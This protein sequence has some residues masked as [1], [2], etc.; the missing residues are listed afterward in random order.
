MQQF[1]DALASFDAS[2]LLA[3]DDVARPPAIVGPSIVVTFHELHGLVTAVADALADAALPVVAI[4]LP[5]GVPQIAVLYGATVTPSTLFLPIDEMQSVARNR[6]L[7]RD[8]ATT[9]LVCSPTSRLLEALQTE[10]G[11]AIAVRPL[12]L[13]LGDAIVL[14]TWRSAEMAPPIWASDAD[15]MY[16]LYTSGSTGHPKGVIGSY[17]ATWHRLAWMWSTVPFA[18]GERVLRHTALTSSATNLLGPCLRYVVVSGEPLHADLIAA[19]FAALPY[20]QLLHLY[21]STEVAGDATFWLTTTTAA[22]VPIGTAIGATKLRLVDAE[23]AEIASDETRGELYIGGPPLARGYVNPSDNESHRFCMLHGERW[24]K[25]GDVAYWSKGL[26]FFCGRT[27]AGYV[28]VSGVQVHVAAIETTVRTYLGQHY[29]KWKVALA[30]IASSEGWHQYDTLV[31]C[32]GMDEDDTMDIDA[33]RDAVE[34]E[35]PRVAMHVLTVPIARFPETSSG[36]ADPSQIPAL[37]AQRSLPSWLRALLPR[38]SGLASTRLDPSTTLTELGLNSM[39]MAIVLHTLQSQHEM[40]LR[41]IELADMTVADLQA[42]VQ[43]KRPRAISPEASRKRTRVAPRMEAV[44]WRVRAHKCID[45]SPRL[46]T[47]DV[48]EYIIVGSHDHTVLCVAAVDGHVVW[49]KELPDRVESSAAVAK[50]QVVVGCYDGGVYCLDVLSGSTLWVFF[51]QDQVKCS[52]VIVE[53]E[54]AVVVGSHD[55]HV[56]G[57]A[58][59]S[60]ACLFKLPFT[61]SVFSSPVYAATVL[62]CA[63]LAGE[64]R[65]YAW[66]SLRHDAPT[67]L[68]QHT[69]PAPVFCSLRLSARQSVLLV[70]CADASLYAL[71]TTTGTPRWSA[72][73]TKPIFSAPRIATLSSGNEVALFGSHDGVVRC[74]STADGVTL[75]LVDLGCTIYASP[76]I[77]SDR[78]TTLRTCVCTT[79]GHVYLWEPEAPSSPATLLF[80]GA[81]DIFS[82]PLVLMDESTIVVGTRGDVLVALHVPE[83][84]ASSSTMTQ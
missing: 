61:K 44:R 22:P 81:G 68:W 57:L 84:D 52:P 50:N 53:E 38:T 45:A 36:K 79:D 34:R 46:A 58:L 42:L 24:F 17:A 69:C 9:G 12:T 30:P 15:A 31:V 63:S 6:S 1:H 35:H 37:F 2:R 48:G 72:A 3:A 7:L 77:I 8:A 14:A 70:G 55:H 49:R 25:T 4:A 82:S 66:S 16:V 71:S 28:K 27:H 18:R 11:D 60:G 40:T 64:V 54:N 80:Q 13:V 78:A 73:T 21:G 33:L 19:L 56:Y 51:T 74:V 62:Y 59:T 41:P 75:A 39:A 83:S 65:A 29:L 20:V 10:F 76:A 26:L 67:P 23:G 43:R 5:L 47:T 32:V